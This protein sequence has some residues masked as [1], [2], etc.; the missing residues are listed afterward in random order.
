MADDAARPKGRFHKLAHRVPGFRDTGL[1]EDAAPDP[2]VGQSAVAD[3]QIDKDTVDSILRAQLHAAID[4][5]TEK[6]ET[7]SQSPEDLKAALHDVVD[8]ILN[9]CI[10]DMPTPD[11]STELAVRAPEGPESV[12][13]SSDA[14]LEK[15]RGFLEDVALT[16]VPG[17]KRGAM[18]AV[19]LVPGLVALV[20]DVLREVARDEE[21]L[22][23]VAKEVEAL[24]ARYLDP[25]I[26]HR[27]VT[28]AVEIVRRA[29]ADRPRRDVR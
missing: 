4:I 20:V 27:I 13:T 26:A 28:A 8:D 11:G 15:L 18:A 1:A 6:D 12:P 10:M 16:V 24:L 7:S 19:K 2:Y 14:S 3:G 29:V 25:K 23:G 21:K 9:Q 22:A 17:A 5:V